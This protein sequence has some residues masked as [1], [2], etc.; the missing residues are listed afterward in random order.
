[1]QKQQMA[2]QREMERISKAKKDDDADRLDDGPTQFAFFD[3]DAPTPEFS[4]LNPKATASELE[5][6][7]E[8]LTDWKGNQLVP[9][10][11]IPALRRGVAVQ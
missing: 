9:D 10:W 6:V 4:F 7:I 1:M 8:G 2:K 3:E 5:S 11:A